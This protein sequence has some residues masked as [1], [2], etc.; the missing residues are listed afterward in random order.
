VDLHLYPT[1]LSRDGA[2]REAARQQGILFDYRHFTYPELCE[3]LY[4]SEGLPGQLIDNPAQTVFVRQ[5][6][7]ALWDE[8]PSPGLVAEYRGL[9]DEL[10]G[11]GLEV[12]EFARCVALI[13]PEAPEHVRLALQLPLEVWRQYQSCLERAGLVDRGDRDLAVLAHLRRHLVAGTKPTIL[14]HVRRIIVHDVYHLSLVHYALVSLLIKLLEDGGVLQHFSSSANV[15]AVRFA[16]Y[17]WQR[18]VADE[19]L[20]NLVLP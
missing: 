18:F 9:V 2:L 15:D 10:K 16:E 6:I 20:A 1:T 3:R 13:A 5:S 4:R 19:S 17:T 12:A 7:A 11:V 8:A 14:R